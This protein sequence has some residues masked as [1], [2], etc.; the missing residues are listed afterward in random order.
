MLEPEFDSVAADYQLQLAAATRLSGE[1]TEYFA[2]YKA[3]V[4]RQIADAHGCTPHAVLDFGSGIG[5]AIAPL[6]QNFPNARLTCLDVSAGSLE[7]SRQFNGDEVQYRSY[8]GCQVPGDIGQFDLIFTACVFHHIPAD[9]HV[10]LLGQLRKL[11]RPGGIFVLFEHNPWN[12]L[13]RHSVN[14]CPFDKNAVLISA[15]VMRQRARAAGFARCTTS[16][17]LFFPGPLA[18]LRPLERRMTRIPLGAQYSLVA[19]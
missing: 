8:D 13:T 10:D 3:V 9:Q 12:P 7:L 4:A 5:S 18:A 17:R 15:P 6:R 2:Q 14:T 11:L 19:S 16:Y 1:S